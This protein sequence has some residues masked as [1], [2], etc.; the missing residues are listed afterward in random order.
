[1]PAGAEIGETHHKLPCDRH[2]PLQIASGFGPTAAEGRSLDGMQLPLTAT[3]LATCS[4]H[5]LHLDGAC[6]QTALIV[7]GKA[8]PVAC[9]EAGKLAC[10]RRTFRQCPVDRRSRNRSSAAKQ[11]MGQATPHAALLPTSQRGSARTCALKVQSRRSHALTCSPAE[12]MLP[13]SG[14][15]QLGM[16]RGGTSYTD[17]SACFRHGPCELS[18]MR[19]CAPSTTPS[20][21]TSAQDA[22]SAS[23]PTC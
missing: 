8:A 22:S 10:S 6:A 3:W 7:V 12:V 23:G 2:L 16:S 21:W 18:V 20:S 15:S 19:V 4:E 5:T 14:S 11:P 9:A 13:H 17:V 1:M